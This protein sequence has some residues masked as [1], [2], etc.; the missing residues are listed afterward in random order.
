[1]H[2]VAEVLR[3][4]A[5]TEEHFDDSFWEGLHGVCNALDNLQARLYVDQRCVYYQKSLLE[6]GTLGTKG[7]VQAGASPIPLTLHPQ[8]ARPL[9][10]ARPTRCVL[11]SSCRA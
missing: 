1:M 10:P 6:S 8:P 11:R 5:D 4:G 2:V 9:A 3:M 7:N